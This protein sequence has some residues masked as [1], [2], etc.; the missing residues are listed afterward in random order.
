MNEF[1]DLKSYGKVIDS[2]SLDIIIFCFVVF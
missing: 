2:E 1:L